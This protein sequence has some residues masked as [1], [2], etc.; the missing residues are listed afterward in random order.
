[1][2]EV[3]GDLWEYEPADAICITTNGFVKADGCAVM[4]AG[5]AREA[6]ERMPNVTATLGRMLDASGNKV[7]YLGSWNNRA[8]LSFPVKHHWREH[9]DPEL[10]KTSALKL[11]EM[12]DISSFMR[13]VIIPRPGCGNGRLK[14]ED[15]KPVLEPI[16]DN[17]FR[18]IT[19]A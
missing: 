17:R 9:A 18:I 1:M 7:H 15:V 2:F 19:W 5:C 8:V 10:I 11:V 14:W 12:A 16:L 4:G 6:T 13:N 3:T